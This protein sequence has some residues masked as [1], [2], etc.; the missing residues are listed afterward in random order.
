MLM[1]HYIVELNVRNYLFHYIVQ[2][3]ARDDFFIIL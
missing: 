1:Y 3:N 2:L